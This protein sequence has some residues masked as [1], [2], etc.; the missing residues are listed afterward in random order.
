MTFIKVKNLL[1]QYRQGTKTINAVDD[2]DLNLNKGEFLAIIGSSGSGKSTLLQLIGGLDRPTKGI[3][4]IDGAEITKIS[5]AKLTT[6][7]RDKIGFIFQNFN[8]I[9]T[10]TA[11]Q[12]VEAVIAK[13]TKRDRARVKEVLKKVGLEERANHLPSLLSGGEQQRVAIARALINEPAI[14][15]ADEPTGNLDSKTGESIIRILHDLNKQNK[16]T[17]ILV[18][19]SDYVKKYA[20]QTIEIKDGKIT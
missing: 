17:V 3:I 1:K 6:L 8:L 11:A 12:N 13:R 15:L 10:L 16:K 14:I 20:D 9:P 18:T 2:I 7:R 4:E 19:H 5:D